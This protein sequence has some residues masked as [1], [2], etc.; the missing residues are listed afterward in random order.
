MDDFV[1]GACY[2]CVRRLKPHTSPHRDRLRKENFAFAPGRFLLSG[3]PSQRDPQGTFVFRE[4]SPSSSV[5]CS[6][7]LIK[8]KPRR[9]GVYEQVLP[10]LGFL[11]P[12]ESQSG[13]ADAEKGK[14]GRLWHTDRCTVVEHVLKSHAK[15]VIVVG[16]R[17]AVKGI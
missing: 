8:D 6:R 13:Q 3:R 2:T 14:G 4:I 9:S 5:A 17:H 16:E 7:T 10:G 1:G 15:G 12:A 11:A